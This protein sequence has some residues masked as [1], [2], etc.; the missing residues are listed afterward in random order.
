MVYG[1]RCGCAFLIPAEIEGTSVLIVK[2]MC[3][4]VLV[5]RESNAG[6]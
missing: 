5:S 3:C 6:F 2:A 1:R 4:V